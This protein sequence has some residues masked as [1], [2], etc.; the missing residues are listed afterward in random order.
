MRINTASGYPVAMYNQ[1]VKVD[2]PTP[3]AMARQYL[4][5]AAAQ[6]GIDQQNLAE[7]HVSMVRESQA[8]TTV[9]LRQ[10]RQNI[11]VYRAELA[12]TISPDQ[13]VTFVSSSYQH[14]IKPNL[15]IP[16]LSAVEA[17]EV[18][19]NYLDVK[20][21]VTDLKT[22]LVLL[23]YL[24]S[25]QMYHKVNLTTNDPMGHW[26]AL[27]G[28]V[29]GRLLTVEDR[30][31]YHHDHGDTPKDQEFVK[32]PMLINGTGYV[33]DPDPLSTARTSY[34][35]GYVDGNDAATSELNA[36]R[37]TVI[38]KDLT[39]V[40]ST[41][42]LVGPYAAI[43]E[44]EFPNKGSFSQASSA[45]NFTRQSD[46]FEAVNVYYHLDASMRYI[47]E[48]LDLGIMPYQ[49]SGGVK[50][51]PHGLSGADNSHYIISSGKLAFGEG[52]VDDGED[53]DIVH[54]EL[55]HGLHDWV[56]GGSLSQVE[57]LSE[58]CGDYWAV[59]YNRSLGHWDSSDAEYNWVFTWDG[60]NEFW[61]GRVVN[62][63]AAYPGG[64]VNQVH[65]DGQIWS[66]AMMKVWD[67]I[68]KTKA[69]KAFWNGIG[70]TGSTSN[71]NDAANVVFQAA[72]NMGYNYND[73]VSMR[74]IFV[75]TGYNMAALPSPAPNDEC[76]TAIAITQ[77]TACTSTA[78]TSQLASKSLTACV[79]TAD[80]DVWY[81]FVATGS[82]ATVAVTGNNDYDPVLEL[83]SA[84]GMAIGGSCTNNNGPGGT[85]TY[86]ASQLTPSNTYYIRVYHFSDQVPDDWTFNICVYGMPAPPNDECAGAVVLSV[87]SDA[88][89]NLTTS[90]SLAGATASQNQDNLCSGQESDDVW[91]AFTATSS[92]HEVTLS[93][94]QGG[95]SAL[96]W[97]VWKGNCSALT[98]VSCQDDA[99]NEGLSTMVDSTYFIRV[100]SSSLSQENTTFDIC[101]SSF[102][103]PPLPCAENMIALDDQYLPQ[104]TYHAIQ[105]VE[106]SGEV[107]LP[108]SGNVLFKSGSNIDLNALFE[109]RAGAIF[110]VD[111]QP[112]DP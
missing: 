35:G 103:E 65:T 54:H 108:G 6:L 20:G 36:A 3:E 16:Q 112:C 33:F 55:G 45:F 22:E 25:E 24:K 93:N 78:G 77:T 18:V 99:M 94:I 60:H 38:L 41:Y 26:E 53:S 5:T 87:N 37:S 43:D 8:G 72:I 101:V 12:I 56:T 14:Q 39:L 44:F 9:R 95:T 106:T 88:N 1:R 74:N 97:S 73:L 110:T 17:Q 57:G 15:D 79:G 61:G 10:F 49:Y 98:L 23:D 27:V 47:N 90:G 111:I 48:T 86:Q 109:V 84:C 96:Y 4:M 52:G 31:C 63:G 92:V 30:A 59:S 104:G 58:G 105:Q 28:A 7:L 42:T 66:T 46:A 34:G 2:A 91:F 76:A 40:G 83:F 67:A 82:S 13:F 100:Y 32:P 29:S 85:E 107:I 62:Y 81:K 75:S 68:G 64:L 11:P 51:D 21:E 19:F 80:D 89:C 71:Q 70:M 102:P 50:F 69:D